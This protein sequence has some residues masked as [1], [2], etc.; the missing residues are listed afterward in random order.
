M[1][2]LGP[3]LHTNF[4]WSPALFAETV[5]CSLWWN[6]VKLSRLDHDASLTLADC[7]NYLSIFLNNVTT[8][9]TT[10]WLE[11]VTQGQRNIRTKRTQKANIYLCHK[12]L[13]QEVSRELEIL[14]FHV[15]VSERVLTSNCKPQLVIPGQS[16]L[17]HSSIHLQGYREQLTCWFGCHYFRQVKETKNRK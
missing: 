14:F 15:L 13:L 17:D 9:F 3:T 7:F 6:S 11:N 16:C 10:I 5:A 12:L 8:S 4:S 2:S 1:S